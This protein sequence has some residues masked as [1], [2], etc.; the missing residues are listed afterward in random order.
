MDTNAPL[1][2]VTASY[3]TRDGAVEDF[4]RVWAT[5]YD[6]GFHHTA[7]AVLTTAAGD[8]LRVERANSTAKH[9][10]WG[11]ALLGG[12]LFV[13]APA[14]GVEMLAAVGVT[15]AGPIIRHFRQNTDAEELSA[16]AD[17]LEEDAW[18]LVVVVVNRRGNVITP[19]LTQAGRS[20]SVDVQW[21]GLEEELCSDVT[22][23]LSVAARIAS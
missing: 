19:L 16:V 11:G 20:V 14:A 6:G 13:L 12:A 21:A 2:L 5:R 9:L 4:S 15:G 7:L 18:S 17:P 23:S 3:S 10:A 22:T 8:E 1:S